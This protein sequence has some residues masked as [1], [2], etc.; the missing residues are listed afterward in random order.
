MI[1]IALIVVAYNS[2][3]YINSCLAPFLRIKHGL[4]SEWNEV[5]E[6]P[7]EEIDIKICAVSAVFKNS[8]YNG[9]ENEKTSNILRNYEQSG[10]IEKYIEIKNNII[11][12]YES[13]MTAWE[14]LKDFDIDYVFQLDADEFWTKEQI[15]NTI[16][17][18]KRYE[19]T[20]CF[21]IRFKNYI[22]KLEDKTYVDNFYPLRIINNKLNK[23]F[24]TFTWDN[25]GIWNNG[26]QTQSA[27][28]IIIPKNIAFVEHLSWIYEKDPQRIIN[29][30]NFQKSNLGCCSYKWNEK[31]NKL[32]FD[33][34]YHNRYNISVPE[35]QK[36]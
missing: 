14:Y 25:D 32:V 30:I 27:A 28:S 22:G 17:L 13:R 3:N 9:T 18:I 23:G 4:K 36:D 24:K 31:E 21:K 16:N 15:I 12:D 1:K 29:K 8:G 11:E 33:L 2:E 35:I 34:E 5:I 20:E 6:K 10:A 19:F 7:S 26:K